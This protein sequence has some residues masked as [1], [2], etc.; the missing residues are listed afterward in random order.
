[1]KKFLLGLV[2]LL[3][4]GLTYAQQNFEKA[5]VIDYQKDTIWGEI[6]F[7]DWAVNPDKIEFK[8]NNSSN[9]KSY[10]PE[11][12]YAF[13]VNDQHFLSAKVPIGI[14]AQKVANLE[15][16]ATL[17]I[18]V[19]NVFLQKLVIGQKSLY[20]FKNID[21]RQYFYIL[22]QGKL[23][24]LEYKRFYSINPEGTKV[25]KENNKYIGQLKLYLGNCQ[26]LDKKLNRTKYNTV[27]MLRLFEFYNSCSGNSMTVYNKKEKI[28]TKFGLIVG[29][30]STSLTF[31][32][33]ASDHRDLV[34]ANYDLDYGITA[35]LSLELVFPKHQRKWSVQNELLYSQY[36]FSKEVEN[37]SNDEGYSY[38]NSDLG[39]SYIK[40]NNMVRYTFPLANIKTFL[41]IGLSNGLAFNET[42]E[43]VTTIMYNNNLDE[44][45]DKLIRDTRKYEQGLL[46]GAGIKLK[47]ISIEY[48]HERG[49]GMS[50]FLMLSSSVIR[51]SILVNFQF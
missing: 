24:L 22:S 30:S 27:S 17:D 21:D 38:T 19:K 49:N 10:A 25:V 32:S 2:V 16:N 6:D 47:Y 23:T 4:N 8:E 46:L 12:I 37:Y 45:P 18:E 26:I 11:D 34:D 13:Q 44:R 43:K 33:D 51:N 14:D 1:M 36:N 20:R 9:V 5:Y 3:A 42:N 48:R 41:N 35:G 7:R 40:L 50:K 28:T 29:Y 15:D 39:Y 31:K